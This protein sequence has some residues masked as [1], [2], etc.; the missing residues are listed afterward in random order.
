MSNAL[1]LEVT[2]G[3]IAVVTGLTLFAITQMY[4][5]VRSVNKRLDDI[6]HHRAP[7]PGQDE[8]DG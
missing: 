4:K 5:W 2:N 1:F 7:D 6:E 3:I 8:P